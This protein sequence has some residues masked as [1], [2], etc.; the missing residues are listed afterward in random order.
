MPSFGFVPCGTGTIPPGPNAVSTLGGVKSCSGRSCT[1][2]AI[3]CATAAFTDFDT[4]EPTA[5]VGSAGSAAIPAAATCGVNPTNVSVTLPCD[6][7]V[8]PATG[9]PTIWPTA[10]AVPPLHRP[11]VD[12]WP[13][14]Q[15]AASVAARAISGLITRPHFGSATPGTFLWST[16]MI[17]VTG[18]A[19][20]CTPSAATVAYA[21][22]R[23][24]GVVSAT[25]RVNDPSRPRPWPLSASLGARNVMPSFCAIA[26]A[27]SAPTCSSRCTK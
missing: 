11:N 14:G 4:N 24:S 20:Q 16:P 27:L 17:A 26:T 18:S 9:R 10:V 1:A 22:A 8:L 6:E 23:S 15:R 3:V 21:S 25:P 7:P 13:T 12:C 19:L 2:T 5:L